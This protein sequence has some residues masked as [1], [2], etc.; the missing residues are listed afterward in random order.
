V[1]EVQ[2]LLPGW[3]E[4][5]VAPGARTLWVV[6]NVT[7][8]GPEEVAIDW[9][10][11]SGWPSLQQDDR[12]VVELLA[13][14]ASDAEIAQELGLKRARVKYIVRHLLDISGCEDR[15][16]LAMRVTTRAISP[17]TSLGISPVVRTDAR[18]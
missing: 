3:E 7:A 17:K 8:F 4:G 10:W 15:F 2:L 18:S 14:K 11:V 13:R 9:H 16:E 6:D 5:A 12:P 1:S